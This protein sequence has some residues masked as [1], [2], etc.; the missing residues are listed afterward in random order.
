MS[1]KYEYGQSL[2]SVNWDLVGMELYSKDAL[3]W[4]DLF[5]DSSK[6]NATYMNLRVNSLYKKWSNLAEC[7]ETIPDYIVS[8]NICDNKLNL[9]AID[10]LGRAFTTLRC[11]KITLSLSEIIERME[12][13]LIHL[14]TS[15]SYIMDICVVDPKGNEVAHP[16]ADLLKKNI[17]GKVFELQDWLIKA[18]KELKEPTIKMPIGLYRPYLF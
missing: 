15:M 14:G 7:F 2:R 6:K 3:E 10:E 9:M 13:E 12:E 17:G 16:S 1:A 5:R 18:K 4:S 11:K 8:L